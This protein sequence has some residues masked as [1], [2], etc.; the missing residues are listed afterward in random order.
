M[1]N[2]RTPPSSDPKRPHGP[3]TVTV[4]VFAPRD[5]TSK[6]F[7]WPQSMKAGEAAA[8]AAAAFGYEGGTPTFQD[9]EGRVLDRNKP[10][11]A[12]GVRDGDRLELV[13]AGGGV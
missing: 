13:D 11:V 4:E 3:P 1:T 9:A 8:E 5:P 12:A 10:L 2:P 6:S 7:T